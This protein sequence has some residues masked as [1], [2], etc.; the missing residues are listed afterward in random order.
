MLVGLRAVRELAIAEVLDTALMLP[1]GVSAVTVGFGYLITMD[2]LP[3]DLRTSP[4]LVP[5]A[6]A[7]VVTPL[8][9]RMVLPVLRSVDERLRQAAATLGALTVAGVA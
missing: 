5:L 3:G 6:Q 7:L 9:V 2:A 8:I 4:L 1:L